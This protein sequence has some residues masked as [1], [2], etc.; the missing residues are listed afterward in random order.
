MSLGKLFTQLT[1]A[2]TRITTLSHLNINT[3]AMHFKLSE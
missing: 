3:D 1:T 2:D